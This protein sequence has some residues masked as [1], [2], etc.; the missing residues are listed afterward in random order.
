M[1]VALRR[2]R[3]SAPVEFVLVAPLVLLVF[4]AIVQVCLAVHVRATLV[5]AA[6]EGAR[7]AA[8]SGGTEASAIRRTRVALSTSVADGVV[9][10][11][12]VRR[13]NEGGLPVQIVEIKA[14]LPLVGLVGPTALTVTGRALQEGSG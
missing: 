10:D 3:G 4:A 1:T 2:Q 7:A 12:T 14:T 5:A 11:I 8:E 9:D 13:G 6:A